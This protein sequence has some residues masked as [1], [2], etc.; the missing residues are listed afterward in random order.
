MEAWEMRNE[1]QDAEVMVGSD[2]CD[3]HNPTRND[4]IRFA[5]SFET[6]LAEKPARGCTRT[7]LSTPLHKTQNKQQAHKQ[8]VPRHCEMESWPRTAREPSTMKQQHK[9]SPTISL[10]TA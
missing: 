4:K 1:L 2:S 3:F 5:S 10:S 9:T 7:D 6:S 8:R